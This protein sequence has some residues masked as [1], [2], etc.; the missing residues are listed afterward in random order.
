MALALVAL[1]ATSAR[2]ESRVSLHWP[3]FVSIAV[4]SVLAQWIVGRVAFGGDPVMG[5]LYLSL[6]L[7][8]ILLGA[9]LKP[10]ASGAAPHELVVL[11]VGLVAGACA[12]VAIALVQWT[13]SVSLGLWGV[14]LAPGGR[15]YGNVGQPN[16]LSTICFIGLCG[17]GLLRQAGRIGGLGFWTGACWLLAG[18]VMTGS[19]TGWLQL[20]F[21]VIFI[22]I[23]SGPYRLTLGR[24]AA[25]LLGL[26]FVAMF[27][28]WPWLN[29]VLLLG[30]G[31]PIEEVTRAGTRRLHWAA[32]ADAVMR[33]PLW[34]YGWQQ[35]SAAQVR[36]ADVHPLV[37]E[38]IE[39]AHN[40][41][42]DLLLWNGIPVGSLLVGLAA[43]WFISRVVQ[44][45]HP[46]AAWLLM[47][48]GCVFIHGLLEYPLEYAYFLLPVGVFIGAI[49]ALENRASMVRVPAAGLRLA[50]V[51]MSL[52]LGAVG[53]DYLKAEES[54][55]TIRLES[56]RI[57]VPGL[58]TP[59][60]DLRL[61]T[62][63]GAFMRFIHTE[64]R[65]GM[66]PEEVEWMRRVSERFAYPSVMFRYALAAG[67]N[68]QPDTAALTLK[69]LC[70]MHPQPRCEEAH[71]AWSSAREK[72]PAL[73]GVEAPAMP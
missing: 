56:A 16:H 27:L 62:Q 50:G 47:G 15:P 23:G 32:L 12:S 59:P 52:L 43:W 36:V 66:T 28:A 7:A 1:A 42:L 19:R 11:A 35:V 49:D 31:R 69:R 2:A 53:A 44:G 21:V 4:V 71:E 57:G 17:L 70:R 6:L 54:Y 45:R 34:G 22:A 29:E 72:F 67:L 10:E 37:G 14:E 38:H 33:E 13:G 58:Q 46:L 8:A 60:P 20:G 3:A 55:R 51:V 30:G 5:V 24:R 63:L 41:I 40:I 64:A 26:L 68:G 61:L 9:T 48:V 18:A 25:A 65:A 73:Q 39:H